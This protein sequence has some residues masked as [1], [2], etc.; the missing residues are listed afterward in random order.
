MPV[1]GS[2]T[3]VHSHS[4]S[5]GNEPVKLC[6]LKN[7]CMMQDSWPYLLYKP[8]SFTFTKDGPLIVAMVTKSMEFYH[9]ICRNA[10]F[11]LS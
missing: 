10:T 1:K 5:R 9:N 7:P 3:R 4:S 2:N 6:D 8:V 11:C